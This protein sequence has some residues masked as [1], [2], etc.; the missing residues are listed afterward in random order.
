MVVEDTNEQNLLTGLAERKS[1]ESLD[2]QTGSKSHEEHKK[3][4]MRSESVLIKD[5]T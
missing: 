5:S 2:S 1:D 4:M 3:H